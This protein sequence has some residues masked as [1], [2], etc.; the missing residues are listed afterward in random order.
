MIA[1]HADAA[2]MP[3]RAG[4]VVVVA[5][6][7]VSKTEGRC[8]RLADVAPSGRAIAL[9]T[10]VEKD[11][12]LVELILRESAAIVRS[13]PGVLIVRH[14]L[15]FIVANAAIDQSN[16]PGDE[17]QALLLPADPDASAE[18]LRGALAG[19]VGGDV[20]V[21]VNDSFGRPFREGTCGVAIGAAGLESLVDRRGEPDR[22][23]RI[24]AATVI[25]HADELAAAASIV[26]GQAEEG[27][28]VAI[29]RGAARGRTY[30]PASDLLRDPER[31]LFA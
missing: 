15:G 31:D 16:L 27:T 3:I 22:E 23:G 20:A 5:Q 18:R 21:I 9:A 28:P 6:K 2:E 14:R 24:M 11:P 1:D 17:D 13:R 30:R 8:V 10:E 29:I 4:D 19:R 25:A 26:M 12:R 7:I